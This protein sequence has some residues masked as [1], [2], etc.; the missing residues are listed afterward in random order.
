MVPSHVYGITYFDD[1]IQDEWF[2]VSLL[3]ELTRKI[4]GLVV[5]VVDADGEFMLIEAAEH[6]PQWAN[7]ET[8]SQRVGCYDKF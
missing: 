2:V 1:N 4:E 8:C 6:L 3:F 7:P 5:R